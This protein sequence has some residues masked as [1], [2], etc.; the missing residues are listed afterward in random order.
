MC[1]AAADVEFFS[2]RGTSEGVCEKFVSMKLSYCRCRKM[3]GNFGNLKRQF[4]FLRGR[5]RVCERLKIHLV[6]LT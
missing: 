1:A 5:E 6:K 3:T 4:D 2:E